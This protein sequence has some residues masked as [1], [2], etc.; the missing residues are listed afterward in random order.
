MVEGEERDG[1][2]EPAKLNLGRSSGPHPL[3]CLLTNSQTGGGEE[4]QTEFP[5]CSY[6]NLNLQEVR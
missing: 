4:G 5:I 1:G 6:E 3:N 2:A